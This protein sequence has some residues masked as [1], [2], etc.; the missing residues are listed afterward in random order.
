MVNFFHRFKE[1]FH[2]NH[3]AISLIS[4]KECLSLRKDFYNEEGYPWSDK[5]A[6]KDWKLIE[7]IIKSHNIH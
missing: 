4:P 3:N 2:T 6:R 1:K 5:I 7:N